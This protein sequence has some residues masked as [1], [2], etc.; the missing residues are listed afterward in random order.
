MSSGHSSGMYW[1]ELSRHAGGSGL[2]EIWLSHPAVRAE[3]NRRISGQPETWPVQWLRDRLI[4]RLPLQSAV[5][6][7]C[8]T[9]A[10]ER[11]LIEKEICAHITGIDTVEQ[12]LLRASEQASVPPFRGRI[13]YE[14]ADALEFLTNYFERLDGIFFHAS[15]HHFSR[16]YE[17]VAA[18]WRS[19]RPGGILY[20]DEYV[21]PSRQQWHP[22]RLLLP[23][24]IYW[25]LPPG[26]RRA[27]I[28]RAPINRED[29]TEAIASHEIIPAVLSRF[30]VLECRGYG[31]NLLAL[32]FPNLRR[33][34]SAHDSS[35]RETL[36][37][38]VGR[39]LRLEGLLLEKLRVR[40]YHTVLLAEK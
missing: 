6:V 21:G 29:P 16:P 3:V 35:T 5:S 12:P 36:D 37:R 25:L 39:L 20:I 17:I 7:G 9:G 18:S 1:E 38:S 28:V 4:H 23:N 30:R 32:I 2:E 11:D 22:F 33:P 40:S 19:L 31:G 26:A 27:R 14:R 8:G 13:S 15:L 34:T 10:L 24:L